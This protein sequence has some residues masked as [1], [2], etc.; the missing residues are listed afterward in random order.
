MNTDILID[1][2]K[3]LIKDACRIFFLILDNLW[4]NHPKT[5]EEWLEDT[6]E[7][8]EV[9]YLPAYSPELNPDE[10]LNCDP[11][12]G[13]GNGKHV[14]SKDQVEKKVS[15]HMRMLEKKPARAKHVYLTS[16]NSVFRIV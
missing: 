11:K 8:I 12:P 1:F 9:F 3:R 7:R 5:I 15:A 6:S 4:V 2:V 10:Y 13:V 16:T 14:R